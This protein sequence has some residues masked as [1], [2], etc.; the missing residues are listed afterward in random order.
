MPDGSWSLYHGLMA[1]NL[2]KRSCAIAAVFLLLAACAARAP[3]RPGFLHVQPAAPGPAAPGTTSGAVEIAVAGIPTGA[4]VEAVV[5]LDPRGGR[6]PAESL[7]AA[8][9][10]GSTV[11]VRS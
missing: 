4:R 6:H 5:L 2:V 1:E 9:L 10:E 7:T 8:T 3:E 11:A